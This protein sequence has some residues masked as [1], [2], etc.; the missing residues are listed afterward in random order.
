M[1][2]TQL[3]ISHGS[4]DDQSLGRLDALTTALENAGYEVLVDKRFI[5]SGDMWRERIH[6]ALAECHAAIVPF[7]DEALK[8]N[9]ILRQLLY[10]WTEKNIVCSTYRLALFLSNGMP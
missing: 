6:S 4:H 8:S 7:D 2:R 10:R 9:P 1:A 5:T 3:F